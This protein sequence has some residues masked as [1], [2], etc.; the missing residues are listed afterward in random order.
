L[1]RTVISRFPIDL[2]TISDKNEALL[3]SLSE[4]L[5]EDYINN[6]NLKTANYTGK[7]EIVYREYSVRKS[8]PII[9]KADEILGEIYGLSAEEIKFIQNYDIRFR[10][11]E[12]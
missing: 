4:E 9:D 1:T 6:S 2:G 10:V 5:M 7:G 8:K 12:E 11:G 3:I